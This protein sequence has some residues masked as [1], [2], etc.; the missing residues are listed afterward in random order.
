MIEL[1]PLPKQKIPFQ[2]PDG[3]E[4]YFC[5]RCHQYSSVFPTWAINSEYRR[6]DVCQKKVRAARSNSLTPIGVL[7]RRLYH[8]CMYNKESLMALNL[9]E[10]HF[11]HILQHFNIPESDATKIKT[12]SPNFDPIKEQWNYRVVFKKG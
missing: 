4:S 2:N 9:N 7:K 10:D 1:N 5:T 12:I 8:N 3:S 11:R 6:C